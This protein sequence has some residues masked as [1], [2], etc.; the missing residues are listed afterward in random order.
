MLEEALATGKLPETVSRGVVSLLYKKGDPRD[1]RNYRPITLLSVAY[2]IMEKRIVFRLKRIMDQIISS[3]QLGFV[4]G[5]RITEATHYIKLLQALVEEE[6]GEGIVVAMDWEKAFDRC[7]WDYILAAIPALGFGPQFLKWAELMYNKSSP[8]KRAV[9]SG[10]KT[11][12]WFPIG[13]GVPQGGVSS[14]LFF[15][16]VTEALTRLILSDE[17]MVG[18]SAGGRT[19]KISQF[20]DD[21]QL[22][23]RNWWGLPRMWYWVRRYEKATASRA[24]KTKF[25]CFRLGATKKAPL[26]DARKNKSLQLQLLKMAQK[27]EFVTL[28]GI[29]FWEEFNPDQWWDELYVKC[30]RLIACW[31][32]HAW[33]TLHGRAML[34]NGMIYSRFRYPA[35]CMSIPK[36]IMRAI[37][38]DVSA[39]LWGRKHDFEPDEFGSVCAARRW[40]MEGALSMPRRTGLGIGL[41]PW[42]EHVKA[43][44]AMWVV[45][46]VDPTQGEWKS[47][48]DS[49]W[50]RF[51]EGR[52]A[53]FTTIDENSLCRSTGSHK[54]CLP[55]FWRAALGAVR[56]L[57]IHKISGK[58]DRDDARA[59]PVWTGPLFDISQRTHVTSWREELELNTVKDA[60]WVSK[61]K[62]YTKSE[63]YSYFYNKLETEFCKEGECAISRAGDPVPLSDLYS[64]WRGILRELPGE[65]LA[66]ARGEREGIWGELWRYSPAAVSIIRGL[67]W[68]GDQLG[69]RFK[70][71]GLLIPLSVESAAPGKLGIGTKGARKSKARQATPAGGNIPKL[72]AVIR[73]GQVLYGEPKG[74]QF[75]V[76]DLTTKGRPRR[77][78][79]VLAVGPEELRMPLWWG[80]GVCGIAESYFPHPESWCLTGTDCG[81]H[82]LTVKKIT[83]AFME[84]KTVRPNCRANWESRIGPINWGDIGLQYGGQVMSPKD[85]MPHF[86]NVLHRA[87]RTKGKDGCRV[88]S[89]VMPNGARPCIVREDLQHFVLCPSIKGHFE[90]LEALAGVSHAALRFRLFALLES[91]RS[92]EPG[93]VCL[94]KILWKFILI[95][96]TKIELCG[97]RPALEGCW[98]AALRRLHRKFLA[99]ALAQTRWRDLKRYRGEDPLPDCGERSGPIQPFAQL[100]ERGELIWVGGM[101]RELLSLGIIDGTSAACGLRKDFGRHLSDEPIAFRLGGSPSPGQA[102]SDPMSDPAFAGIRAAYRAKHGDGWWNSDRI[103]AS[104]SEECASLG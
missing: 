72:R 71:A 49:W 42:A 55:K 16:F 5:R 52:G 101:R 67:G 90:K 3:P 53:V 37:A 18:V 50:A 103:Y 99:F 59:Y 31:R 24:N 39:L 14:P 54:E 45:R 81:L 84:S 7:S 69:G 47:L 77:T 60:F 78:E 95:R 68:D 4:P 85:W 76:H 89:R 8:P 92:A 56:E 1:V 38:S 19:Y 12:R 25:V 82:K 75:Q 91:G 70:D 58:W 46:Y 40:M 17:H 87:F 79:Q 35:Q 98:E 74:W 66:A 63:I 73:D 104:F 86:K 102:S 97:E 83:S 20:A 6:D 64:E 2:K 29:P 88:C 23:L 10:G 48:L 32:D 44:Q 26:P 34:A 9:R 30:K 96:L 93:I 41:L 43:L 36:Y 28:L 61:Q 57:G 94:H 11:S 65:M 62:E 51:N 27:G 22:F 80:S 15:L 13:S 21:A 100:S 33:L